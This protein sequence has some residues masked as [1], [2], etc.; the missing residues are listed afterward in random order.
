MIDTLLQTIYLL[1]L[2]DYDFLQLFTVHFPA[3][4]DN[5]FTKN[6]QRVEIV[7]NLEVEIVFSLNDL[8]LRFN[9]WRR[10]HFSF[11]IVF[12]D[13]WITVEGIDRSLAFALIFTIFSKFSESDLSLRLSHSLYSYVFDL[14]FN[15]QSGF[16][17][18]VLILSSTSGFIWPLH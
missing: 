2:L 9:S 11:L 14:P 16:E 7:S 13:T 4:S 18:L 15:I 8:C 5:R 6:F 1:L 12:R 3:L 17:K 10:F